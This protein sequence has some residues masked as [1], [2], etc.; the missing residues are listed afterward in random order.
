MVISIETALKDSF[1]RLTWFDHPTITSALKKLNAMIALTGFSDDQLY[2]E[3]LEALY[4]N[5]N[6]L[7]ESSDFFGNLL[8]IGACNT[9]TA[10]NKL[11]EIVDRKSPTMPSHAVT[12]YFDQTQNKTEVPVGILSRPSSTATTRIISTSGASVPY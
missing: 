12:I 2:A 10:F 1:D 5:R 6:C 3:S 7:V 8:R 9:E 4:T 11:N